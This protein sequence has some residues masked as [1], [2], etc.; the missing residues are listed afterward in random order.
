M[1]GF[2]GDFGGAYASKLAR[3]QFV[4]NGAF[5]SGRR[6]GLIGQLNP[7]FDETG[8]GFIGFKFN[9]G[10][11]DQYGWVRI[12]TRSRP[13]VHKFLLLD[14]AYGDLSAVGLLTWRKSWSQAAQQATA[15]G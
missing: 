2:Y 14:Y 3:G 11:G 4:S 12:E 9:N 6:A 5:I 7:Q 15:Q 13:S 8:I 10:S 1:V